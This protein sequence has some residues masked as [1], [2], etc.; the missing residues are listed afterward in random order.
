MKNILFIVILLLSFGTCFSKGNP[1]NKNNDYAIFALVPEIGGTTY[2]AYSSDSSIDFYAE[3]EIGGSII[4]RPLKSFCIK[5]GIYYHRGIKNTQYYS[6]PIF[7]NFFSGDSDYSQA[8]ILKP[9][10]YFD[11][12]DNAIGFKNPKI[13]G[14]IGIGNE[15]A[16]LTFYYNPMF[17]VFQNDYVKTLKVLIGFSLKLGLPIKII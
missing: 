3:Y 13:G 6:I 16:S 5:P 15:F 12:I 17:P 14:G 7:L 11:T 4:I 1:S 10:F 2:F 9:T 8:F